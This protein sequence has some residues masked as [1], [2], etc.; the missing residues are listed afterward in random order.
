[1]NEFGIRFY[2]QNC[3]NTI[4]LCTLKVREKG[5]NFVR[6]LETRGSCV[7]TLTLLAKLLKKPSFFGG[8]LA[9]INDKF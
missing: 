9:K 2:S 6:I 4:A 7:S 3:S 5:A 1:M 8:G